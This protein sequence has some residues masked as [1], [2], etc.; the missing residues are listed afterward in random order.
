MNLEALVNI[1]VEWFWTPW[2]LKFDPSIPLGGQ[3]IGPRARGCLGHIEL[4]L[5]LPQKPG[6]QVLGDGSPDK[7]SATPTLDKEAPQWEG[8]G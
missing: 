7:P 8:V 4:A 1:V 3:E 5:R 6:E 2:Q